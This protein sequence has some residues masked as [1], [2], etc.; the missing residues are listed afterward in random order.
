MISEALTE[1]TQ[2][3]VQQ[4]GETLGTERMARCKW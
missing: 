4:T 1:G 3:V 2:S